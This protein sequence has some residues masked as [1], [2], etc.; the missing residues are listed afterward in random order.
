MR[1]PFFYQLASSSHWILMQLFIAEAIMIPFEIA[2]FP[3]SSSHSD[4]Q[5]HSPNSATLCSSG[6]IGEKRQGN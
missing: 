3:G 1:A 2:Q 6:E 5:P 4:P